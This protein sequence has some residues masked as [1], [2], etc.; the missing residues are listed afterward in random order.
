MPHAGREA[1]YGWFSDGIEEQIRNHPREVGDIE[2][3]LV[4]ELKWMPQQMSNRTHRT[5]GLPRAV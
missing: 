4:R 3:R 2:V 5:V 1:W